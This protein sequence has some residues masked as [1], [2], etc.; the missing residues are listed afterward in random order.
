DAQQVIAGART[1]LP[2]TVRVENENTRT[3]VADVD[4]SFAVRSG[5]AALSDARVRTGAD[6]TAR[7]DVTV[8]SAPGE[9]VVI[10]AR[11]GARPAQLF[12]LVVLAPPTVQSISHEV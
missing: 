10:A 11:I 2:L 5:S 1:A 12:R 7:T 8:L 4:V 9:A 6:G 3:V